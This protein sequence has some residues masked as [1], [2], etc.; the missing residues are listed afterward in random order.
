MAL[1]QS[2]KAT[3]TQSIKLAEMNAVPNTE[4]LRYMLTEAT[5]QRKP[6]ILPFKNPA[7][8]LGFV[9]KVSPAIG[10]GGR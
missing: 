10:E 6:V 1:S 8:G 2:F 3:Q 4:D 9:V 7:N 5:M